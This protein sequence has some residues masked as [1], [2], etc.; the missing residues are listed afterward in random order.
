M[1]LALGH[2][3]IGDVDDQVCPKRLLE[4]CGEGLDELVRELADE[5]DGVR[6]QI[7]AALD[8]ERAR[9]GVEGVEEP[10]A[11]ADVRARKRVQQRGFARVR[12]ARERH[13]GQP[14]AP[15]SRRI[16]VRVTC[17]PQPAL[18][19]C[20]ATAREPAIGLDLR[21]ARAPRAD[22]AVEA[23]EVGPEPAHPR[24]V[25]PSW[26]ARPAAC[27]RPSARGRRRCRG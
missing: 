4:R 20:D 27:P 21:L 19:G 2:R 15:R 3:G 1:E 23:L 25:V 18:E 6:E 7:A 26:A 17:V 12:V 10:L 22:S 5:A 9:R 11:H 13:R 14:G 24:E 8:F 16:V